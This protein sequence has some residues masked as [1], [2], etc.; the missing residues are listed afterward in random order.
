[1]RSDLKILAARE[2]KKELTPS[3]EGSIVARRLFMTI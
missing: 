1:M 2:V 3:Y